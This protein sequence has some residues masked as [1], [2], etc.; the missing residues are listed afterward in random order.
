MKTALEKR[1]D[2]LAQIEEERNR[3]S[4]A[5][6]KLEKEIDDNRVLMNSCGEK[7]AAANA[8]AMLDGGSLEAAKDWH[9]KAQVAY[10]DTQLGLDTAKEVLKRRDE[11]EAKAKSIK[12]GIAKDFEAVA[13]IEWD[14]LSTDLVTH[15]KAFLEANQRRL[16]LAATCSRLY[17]AAGAP[18]EPFDESSV[19]RQRFSGEFGCAEAGLFDLAAKAGLIQTSPPLAFRVSR[20]VESL[21]KERLIEIA[22]QAAIELEAAE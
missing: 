19:A 5:L 3:I 15:Y 10:R 2:E 21:P 16:A 6:V 18:R 13:Y 1:F 12:L 20:E 7:A 8:A 14:R 11:A 4:A 9:E 22:R 17:S